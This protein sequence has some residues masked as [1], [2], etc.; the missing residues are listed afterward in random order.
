MTQS[1]GSGIAGLCLAMGLALIVNVGMA[2]AQEPG[3]SLNPIFGNGRLTVTGNGFEPG[4]QVTV[5]VILDQN[6]PQQ[7]TLTADSQGQFS[8][9]TSLPVQPFA[10]VELRAEGDRGTAVAAI[11]SVP[12]APP[13]GP[14][15]SQAPSDGKTPGA[16][17]P[18]PASGSESGQSTAGRAPAQLPRTGGPAVGFGALALA[19]AA[20]GGAAIAGGTVLRRHQ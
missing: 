14:A 19:G 8:L 18:P 4:E 5:T 3:G 13:S 12:P 17:Q 6:A 20:L 15:P 2:A 1:V 11:T 7:F 16:T 10:S 9:E